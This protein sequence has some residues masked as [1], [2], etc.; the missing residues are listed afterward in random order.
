MNSIQIYFK[1]SRLANRY[2][3]LSKH[4]SSLKFTLQSDTSTVDSKEQ[5][6]PQQKSKVIFVLGGIICQTWII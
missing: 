5:M 3:R 6:T 1:A 4:C 2:F